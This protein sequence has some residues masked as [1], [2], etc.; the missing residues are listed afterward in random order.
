VL[1]TRRG[2]DAGESRPDGRRRGRGTR[3]RCVVCGYMYRT[4][5]PDRG[6]TVRRL[7]CAAARLGSPHRHAAV[8]AREIGMYLR[9]EGSGMLCDRP[10]GGSIAADR[11]GDGHRR[12]GV[13]VKAAAAGMLGAAAA[14]LG[15][16]H[17]TT[18]QR[19]FP[20]GPPVPPLC[21]CCPRHTAKSR[22]RRWVRAEG[23]R[24]RVVNERFESAYAH[25]A[26]ARP[27]AGCNWHC[28]GPST[29][30]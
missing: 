9:R 19:C 17:S 15:A 18:H 22:I 7:H 30:T 23:G 11:P 2:S 4:A 21:C 3:P 16:Q 26:P 13:V 5:R 27:P 29:R 6:A 12:Y 10:I 1:P 20:R 24:G 28:S 14:L 8:A 25:S